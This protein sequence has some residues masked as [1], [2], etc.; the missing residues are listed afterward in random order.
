MEYK[1]DEKYDIIKV[2][3]NS[4]NV[5]IFHLSDTKNLS[6]LLHVIEVT[7]TIVINQIEIKNPNI[8]DKLSISFIRSKLTTI[9]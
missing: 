3:I 9:M 1:N 7:P 8:F 4:N 5:E 6:I 2:L